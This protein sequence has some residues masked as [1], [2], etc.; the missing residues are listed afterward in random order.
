MALLEKREGSL[1]LFMAA[2]SRLRWS[3]TWSSLR[4]IG[5]SYFVRL[6]ILIPIVGYL[7]IFNTNIVQY[8]ELAKEFVGALAAPPGS[9]VSPRLLLIYFGLT[10]LAVGSTIYSLACPWEVKQ[11]GTA[12]AYVGGEEPHISQFAF[13]PIIARLQELPRH[14][15]QSSEIGKH[16]VHGGET[17]AERWR[18]TNRDWLYLYFDYLNHRHPPLRWVAFASFL[19]GFFCLFLMLL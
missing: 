18:R 8:L 17:S 9:D 12:S 3:P 1:Q 19:V 2:L 10:A 14:K 5:N 7:I 4:S 15:D 16:S 13:Q 11:Y 6:T